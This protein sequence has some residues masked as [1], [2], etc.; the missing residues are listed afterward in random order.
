MA[1]IQAALLFGG[2]YLLFSNPSSNIS[3]VDDA[4]KTNSTRMKKM[5]YPT[6]SDEICQIIKSLH[7]NEKISI[8]GQRHS[9]GG[10]SL[11]TN[12]TMIDMKNM[13]KVIGINLSKQTVTIQAGITWADLIFFL[14]MYGYSPMIMTSY[15]NFSVGGTLSVNAHG[16]VSNNV[17][18]TSVVELKIINS[19]GNKYLCNNTLNSKLFSL[20]IGGYGLFGIIYEVTLRIIPNCNVKLSTYKLNINNFTKNYLHIVSDEKIKIKFAR[21][22][23]LNFDDIK[24][25]VFRQQNEEKKVISNLSLQPTELTK[26]QQL[27]YKWLLPTTIGLKIKNYIEDKTQTAIDLKQNTT[28][29]ELLYVSAST[30][31]NIYSPLVKLNITH[32]LNEYFIPVENFENWMNSIATYFEMCKSNDCKLLN[33]TIRFVRYDNISFLKYAKYDKMFA[34]VFYFRIVNTTLC[35]NKLKK[36]TYDL[37]NMCLN[38]DGTF[39]LPYKIHYS[40]AQLLQA[41]PNFDNFVLYK[42]KIDKRNIFYNNWINNILKL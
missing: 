1:Y 36:I 21:I 40:K 22:N 17:L 31:N 8:A 41:Y 12:E 14:N 26:T 29:N 6:S 10:H 11:L 35:E 24:L 30:L 32:I 9:M 23:L 42:N 19:E 34:F 4:S 15:S 16:I 38:N 39:Y 3:Y 28:I 2:L 20:V 5:L 27:L 33:I 18:G 37:V 25:Y 7:P 13:N